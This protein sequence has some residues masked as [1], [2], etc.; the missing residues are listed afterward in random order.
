MEKLKGSRE[1]VNKSE[2][3]KG[4]N[5]LREFFFFVKLL[6]LKFLRNLKPR[7]RIVCRGKQSKIK[8][9]ATFWLKI[10]TSGPDQV[11]IKRLTYLSEGGL[12]NES[13]LFVFTMFGNNI[14]LTNK[15]PFS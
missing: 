11:T 7:V 1:I 4:K 5:E 15:L 12:K 10:S 9:H 8:W 3:Q 14:K 2:R 13:T 6:K